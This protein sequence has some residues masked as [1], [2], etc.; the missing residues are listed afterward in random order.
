VMSQEVGVDIEAR[1]ILWV[2]AR[3]DYEPLFSILGGPRTDGERRIWIV[4]RETEG[5]IRGV[6]VDTGQRGKKSNY[7]PGVPCLCGT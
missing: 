5:N 1:C 7:V 6:E 4:P 2:R 3:P